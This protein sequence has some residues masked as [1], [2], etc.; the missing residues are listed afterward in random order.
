MTV[1]LTAGRAVRR[2]GWL[3]RAAVL[4]EE[5]GRTIVIVSHDDG[6]REVA[7]RV[8]RLEDGAFRE[9]AGM[10]TDPV[11][12]MAVEPAGNPTATVDG[13]IWW[14]CSTHY[15]DEFTADPAKFTGRQDEPA[16]ATGQGQTGTFSPGRTPPGQPT[17]NVTPTPGQ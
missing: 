9:L 11:C 3:R 2:R 13:R 8:L 1:W 15:R 6:L 17:M 4:A 10:V 7:D 12:G 16:A 5:D 14:F